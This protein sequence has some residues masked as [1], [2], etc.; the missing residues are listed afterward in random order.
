M[1]ARPFHRRPGRQ[2]LLTVCACT[3]A[4]GTFALAPSAT[5]ITTLKRPYCYEGADSEAGGAS[6]PKSI[7][8]QVI[9][10]DPDR[11]KE[12][13]WLGV[14][15]EEATDV[16]S[17]Q[18]GLEPGDGLVVAFVQPD[19][20]AARAGL[21][22]NDVLVEMGD[23]LLLHPGQFRKLV[24]R[25]KEGDKIKLTLFRSGKKLSLSA[26]LAKT[27]H[28]AGNLEDVAH[29]FQVQL[30]DPKQSDTARQ[31]INQWREASPYAGLVKQVAAVEVQRGV[32]EARDALSQALLRN[33][34]FALALGP[35]AEQVRELTRGNVNLGQRTTITLKKNDKSARTIVKAEETGTYV[36]V[37][38]PTRHLMV[39]DNDGKL[40]FD[41]DIETEAQQEKVPAEIW[42]K[43][44]AMLEELGAPPE[45][46]TR[47]KAS[48]TD[49]EKQ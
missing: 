25:Q 24:R 17:A 39:T 13:A 4:A 47:P 20:P 15:T 33:H 43:A 30:R 22:K 40:L 18:L 35:E 41:G 10:N 38:S 31:N 32:Q 36:I 5:A 1:K 37:A 48:P 19:S 7:K 14:S 34:S 27:T 23:Q 45:D 28:R 42:R 16:L 11:S 21:Q 29:E 2:C 9:E 6:M 49:A 26:T 8:I 46:D 12:V 3:C 44:Q